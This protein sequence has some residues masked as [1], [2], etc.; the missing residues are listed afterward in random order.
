LAKNVSLPYPRD[1][2]ERL[3]LALRTEIEKSRTARQYAFHSLG[4]DADFLMYDPNSIAVQAR[5]EF[6]GDVAALCAFYRFYYGR[7][8]EKRPLQ[9]LAKVAR[10]MQIFYLPYCRAYDPR[11]SRKL[12]GEYQYSVVSLSDPI[13][14]KVWMGYPPAVDFM[15]RTEELGRRELRFRQP[16]LLP[17]IPIAVLLMS[18]S[19]STSLAVALVLAVIVALTSGRWRRLHL[20][21]ALVVFSFSFNAACC[22]EVA[23]INSLEIRR[24][25][26]V[27]MYS[28]L[29]A[30]LF[31]LWFIL[32]FVVQMWECRRQGAVQPTGAGD[33]P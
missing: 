5:R 20:I 2:L 21:A 12:G 26:T 8:W 32:E 28:T 9:V 1:R 29:L 17:L 14:R 15:N 24:Y 22:L 18:I 6:R 25:M 31:G 23:I 10:Q 3:Y 13:C 30:Q 19:Y 11:I 16:L 33:K 4:F 27:Q 7:I